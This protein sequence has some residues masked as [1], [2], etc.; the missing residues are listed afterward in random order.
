MNPLKIFFNLLF[1]VV[2][3]SVAPSEAAPETFGQKVKKKAE[4]LTEK[5]NNLGHQ[6]DSRI[7]DASIT[8]AVKS[9]LLTDS[10]IEAYRINV[11]TK[12]HVVYLKGSVPDKKSMVQAIK[13]ARSIKGV[14]AVVNMLKIEP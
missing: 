11:D 5:A 10:S 8:S 3:V 4:T 7:S 2:C 9:A 12:R 6:A 1:I 14:R 13:K